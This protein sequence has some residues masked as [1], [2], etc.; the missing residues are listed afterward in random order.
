MTISRIATRLVRACQIANRF[1]EAE[2]TA[3]VTDLAARWISNWPN[4]ELAD[5]THYAARMTTLATL[6]PNFEIRRIHQAIERS[7][8]NLTDT[9]QLTVAVAC[10][11]VEPAPDVKININAGSRIDFEGEQAVEWGVTTDKGL[12]YVVTHSKGGAIFDTVTAANGRS[13]TAGRKLASV[14]AQRIQEFANAAERYD[15]AAAID[16]VLLRAGFSTKDVGYP[17]ITAW[18]LAEDAATFI[19]HIKPRNLIIRT[20]AADATLLGETGNTFLRVS[21]EEIAVHKAEARRG[22]ESLT[23]PL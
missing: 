12:R 10:G 7:R 19:A 16:L 17:A 15:A 21:K 2:K 14:T 6:N 23:A 20:S 4:L 9:L 8:F 18:K 11:A 1:Y 22:F 3:S 13:R 5:D